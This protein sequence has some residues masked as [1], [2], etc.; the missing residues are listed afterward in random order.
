MGEDRALQRHDAAAVGHGLGHHRGDD[1][2]GTADHGRSVLIGRVTLPTDMDP[3]L[4]VLHAAV[5]ELEPELVGLRRDLHAHPELARLETRSSRVV[6]DRLDRRRPGPDPA[7]RQRRGRRPRSGGTRIPGRPA[8][9][10]RRPARPRADR[11]CR[12]R[13][14]PRASPTRA[15]TTCIRRI[16]LGA[17]LALATQSQALAAAGLGVRLIFQPA[18]EVIPGGAHE[19]IDGGWLKGVDEVFALHCDPSRDVGEVGLLRRAHHRR[20]R[21]RRGHPQGPR[22]PHLPPAPDPGPHLRARQGHHRGARRPRPP[23]STRAPVPPWSGAASTPAAPTN[24]IPSVGTAGGTL[25]MLDA[26]ALAGDRDARRGARRGRRRAV[27]G[28]RGARATPRG[29]LRSST[30]APPSTRSGTRRARRRA[31]PRDHAAVPRR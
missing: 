8:R 18:E 5:D 9:R 27:C 3:L 7:G 10:P 23:A 12:G 31:G 28:D 21:Q 11:R 17:G 24:V 4:P 29:C 15:G 19:I 13:R 25:R 1:E 20:L 6:A 30:P 2:R 22:R 16:V 26:D 14:R